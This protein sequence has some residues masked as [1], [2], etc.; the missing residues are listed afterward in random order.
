[1]GKL[2]SRTKEVD[3]KALQEYT[4]TAINGRTLKEF[5]RVSGVSIAIVSRLTNAT[6][7]GD[8]TPNT[9]IKL[10]RASE[11]RVSVDDMLTA[12]GFEPDKYYSDELLLTR[13]AFYQNCEETLTRVLNTKK[14]IVENDGLARLEIKRSAAYEPFNNK[15]TITLLEPNTDEAPPM[16]NI[17]LSFVFFYP[18]TNNIQVI[19]H[20]LLELYG[21]LVTKEYQP[22][23]RCIIVVNSEP[24]RNLALNIPPISLPLWMT[25]VL[26]SNDGNDWLED[27]PLNTAGL[28]PVRSQYLPELMYTLSMKKN[29]LDSFMR[30]TTTS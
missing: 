1:M 5:C 3:I 6:V 23:E 29:E 24:I 27:K 30:F 12:G 16:G 26:T 4:K 11:G 8:P 20:K 7:I 18:D 10:A 9:L 19:Q 25:I 13:D 28:N 14:M 22:N 21:N 17:N 15:T 2:V